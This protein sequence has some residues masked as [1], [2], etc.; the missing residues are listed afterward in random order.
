MVVTA[1]PGD[2]KSALLANFAKEYAEKNEKT[3]VLSH[4][5]GASPGSPD[6]RNTLQR[7]CDEL[8]LAF[9][10]TDPVPTEYKARMILIFLIP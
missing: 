4:F 7:L 2:G 1:K 9:D 10:L 8:K 5:I 6:I 3:F